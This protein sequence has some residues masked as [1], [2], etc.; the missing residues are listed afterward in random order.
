MSVGAINEVIPWDMPIWE[1]A[2]IGSAIITS[3]EFITGCIV[4]LALGWNVWDYS[5]IPF[6][7][8]GQICLPYSVLW[9][10]LSVL[11]II[12]DDFLRYKLF[13]ERY[14]KYTWFTR[15]SQN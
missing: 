10:F 4:N 5:G 7:I 3:L 1:Q 11:C 8:M 9:T 12:A 6:N 15:S 14:P 2:L 13:S